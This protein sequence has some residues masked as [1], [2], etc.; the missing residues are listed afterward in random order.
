MVETCNPTQVE[1]FLILQ[2][3]ISGNET[4]MINR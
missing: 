4:K 2:I 1:V 3:K